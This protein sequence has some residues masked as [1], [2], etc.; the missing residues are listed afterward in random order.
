[1]LL[2]DFFGTEGLLFLFE[3]GFFFRRLNGGLTAGLKL[4]LLPLIP[5][6]CPLIPGRR[7]L[8]GFGLRL[9]LVP[10]FF[11]LFLL[12]FLNSGVIFSDSA[13]PRGLILAQTA[14]PEH[15]T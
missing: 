14:F 10:P 2:L 7:I 5:G 4:G 9:L 8:G 6:L 11:L 3:E 12:P 13:S 15:L 1:M